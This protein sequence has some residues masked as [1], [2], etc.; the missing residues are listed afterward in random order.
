MRLARKEVGR[1]LADEQQDDARVR[2]LDADFLRCE[3]KALDVGGDEVDEQQRADEVTARQPNRNVMAKHRD[4]LDEPV[5]EIA[6][7]RV[8]KPFVRLR[9]CPDKHEHDAEGQQHHRQPK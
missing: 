8:V 7:L 6:G 2:E 1:Q 5:F 9:H 4:A 3:L